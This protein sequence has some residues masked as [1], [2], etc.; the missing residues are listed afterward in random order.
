MISM[1]SRT[2]ILLTLTFNKHIH[3]T[4]YQDGTLKCFKIMRFK[5]LIILI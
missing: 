2:K 4:D 3:A 5:N 1:N